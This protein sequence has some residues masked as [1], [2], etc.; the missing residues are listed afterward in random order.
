MQAMTKPTYVQHAENKKLAIQSK[1]TVAD[2]SDHYTLDGPGMSYPLGHRA[3]PEISNE[4]FYDKLTG[5]IPLNS[6]N[7]LGEE[8]WFHYGN[9]MYAPGPEN[10]H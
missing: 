7:L 4:V 10:T 3:G 9:N 8:R 6:S 1:G 2:L 5:G